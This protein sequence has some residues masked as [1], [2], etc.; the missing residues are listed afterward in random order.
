MFYSGIYTSKSRGK[1][2]LLF[3]LYFTNQKI[4]KLFFENHNTLDKHRILIEKKNRKKINTIYC[5]VVNICCHP[6]KLN[7]R[8]II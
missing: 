8:D 5:H 7:L 1:N 4:G 3:C 2:C 6:I